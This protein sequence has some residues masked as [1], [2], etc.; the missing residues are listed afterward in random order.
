M[1]IGLKLSADC[2]PNLS[3]RMDE[4]DIETVGTIVHSVSIYL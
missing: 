4:E 1:R 3:K 2:F